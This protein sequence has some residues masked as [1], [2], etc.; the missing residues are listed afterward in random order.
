MLPSLLADEDL[1]SVRDH[2]GFR[3]L[4]KGLQPRPEATEGSSET[5]A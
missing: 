2:P 3:K 1:R 4:A 5:P